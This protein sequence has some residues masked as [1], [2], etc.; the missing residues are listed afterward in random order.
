[1]FRLS[2]KGRYGLRAMYEIAR[3]YPRPINIKT[4]SERQGVPVRYLEQI[5]NR[6]R[7]AGFIESI[8]GPGGGYVLKRKPAEI[9]LAE[10]LL[11]LVGPVA[12]T[13]CLDPEEGCLRVDRCVFHLLWKA[14][15]QQIENF[16]ST[17]TL[18]D[19]LQEWFLEALQNQGGEH[20]QDQV[21]GKY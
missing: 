14:L 11:E 17:I 8:K 1:M 7:R 18:E 2:T 6:L 15:G 19:L 3:S 16:L 20:E 10:I 5:L 12:I 13:S 9:N 4:I 21:C